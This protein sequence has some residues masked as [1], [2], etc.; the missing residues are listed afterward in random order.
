MKLL[1]KIN[2]IFIQIKIFIY[3][4]WEND[5]ITLCITNI[6]IFPLIARREFYAKEFNKYWNVY[7]TELTT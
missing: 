2:M 1:A 6:A 3:K 4:E 7:I 5:E